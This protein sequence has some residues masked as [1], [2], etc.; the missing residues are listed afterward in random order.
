ME[1]GGEWLLLL[2]L[3]MMVED[4]GV[5]FARWEGSSSRLAESPSDAIKARVGME[6]EKG[7]PEKAC[8]I[9]RRSPLQV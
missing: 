7:L 9:F 2:L 3:T 6:H 4:A 1:S 8:R 5:A